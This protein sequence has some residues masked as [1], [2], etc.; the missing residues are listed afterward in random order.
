MTCPN[1]GASKMYCFDS[2]ESNGVRYRRYKCDRCNARETTYEITSEAYKRLRGLQKA[3]RGFEN[4][5]HKL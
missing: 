2:R 1:C 4:A 3:A 5:M